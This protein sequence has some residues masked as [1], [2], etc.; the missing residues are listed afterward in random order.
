MAQDDSDADGD[1]VFVPPG[2]SLADVGGFKIPVPD[3]SSLQAQGPGGAGTGGEPGG[4]SESSQNGEMDTLTEAVEYGEDYIETIE[5][6]IEAEDCVYCKDVLK[7]L[8]D[9]PVEE[10]LQGVRE[11]KELKRAIAEDPSKEHLDQKM[12]EFEVIDGM[13]PGL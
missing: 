6:A 13:V 5:E 2:M 1:D 10:Q 3:P 9:R 4:E 8:R 12:D 7:Q 11:M